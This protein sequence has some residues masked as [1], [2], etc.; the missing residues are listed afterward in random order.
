MGERREEGR[1]EAGRKSVRSRIE[2]ATEEGAVKSQRRGF[3]TGRVDQFGSKAT[4]RQTAVIDNEEAGE[5]TYQGSSRTQ[6]ER[7]VGEKQKQKQKQ[8][9][10]GGEEREVG[11]VT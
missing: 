10:S 6:L 11:G 1:S 5:A 7:R 3:A 2:N 9:Y 4:R 8:T